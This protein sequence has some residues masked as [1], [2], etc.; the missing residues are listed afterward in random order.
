MDQLL[1]TLLRE[2]NKII[3]LKTSEDTLSGDLRKDYRQRPLSC[4]F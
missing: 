4:E 3:W 2:F 1:G